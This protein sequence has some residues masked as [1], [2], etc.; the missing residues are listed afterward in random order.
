MSAPSGAPIRSGGSVPARIVMRPRAVRVAAYFSGGVLVAG[1]IAGAILL[2]SF[3][4]PGRIGL[5]LVGLAGLG[6]CHLEARVHLVAEPTR[7]VVQN[8][9]SRRVLTWPEILD[10]SF[11]MGDPW[12]HLNLWDG[13]THPLQA[14]QRYDGERAVADAHRLRALIRE[15]GEAVDPA[16]APP[17]DSPR[18][19]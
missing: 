8:V 12:A 5:V 15:R 14:L 17:E 13:R 18:G 4:L 1:M 9:F 7:L 3:L 11:P 2:D 10:I 16:D 6:F 19:S